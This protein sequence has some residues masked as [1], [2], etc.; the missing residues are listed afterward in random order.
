MFGSGRG[1]ESSRWPSCS[2][3]GSRPSSLDVRGDRLAAVCIASPSLKPHS[4]RIPRS[5][6][7]S[8]IYNSLRATPISTTRIGIA[9]AT[10][11]RITWHEIHVSVRD[12]IVTL[13]GEVPTPYD[14]QLVVAITQHVAGVF[15]IDD[16]LTSLIV[17]R[18]HDATSTAQ[19]SPSAS[20]W[21]L[22]QHRQ[23]QRPPLSACRRCR[24]SRIALATLTGC[25]GGDSSRVPVHPAT[26][27]IQFRGQPVVRRVR[28][29]PSERWRRHRRSEPAGNR[30]PRR[31]VRA[32][33][34][35]RP[36]RRTGRRVRAHRAVVQADAP[37]QRA[38]RRAER[39]A[40]K[41]RVGAERP[42]SRSKWP[43]AKTT[44]SQFRLR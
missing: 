6:H 33:H 25:G 7:E 15:G 11:P 42:T 12:G 22:R 20:S 37:G 43:P 19:R 34:V 40:A 44:C 3:C 2:A 30:R 23:P 26:G 1:R 5:S 39:A 13:R 35:R 29:A 41:V 17:E 38:R 27:A 9:F 8:T 18:A 4:H 36:G 28:V 10:R 32:D 16:Q 21:D 24:A 31:Q 14:R